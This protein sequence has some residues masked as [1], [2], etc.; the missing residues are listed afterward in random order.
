MIEAASI[1][2]YWKLILGG[3]AIFALS[4]MLVIQ[5][6]ETRHWKKQAEGEKTAFEKT[7]SDYKRVRAEQRAA[8]TEHARAVEQTQT[9]V[10]NEVSHDYQAAIA[11]LRRRYDALRLRTGATTAHPGGGRGTDVSGLP[12]AAGGPNDPPTPGEDDFN[13]AANFIQLEA[14]QRWVREQVA[15]ER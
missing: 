7:V 4:L 5:K 11:D 3:L 10:S 14:L 8:D 2:K 12:D 9:K 1:L 13:A 6:G 15:V